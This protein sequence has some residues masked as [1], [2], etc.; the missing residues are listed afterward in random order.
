[1]LLRSI[2]DLDTAAQACIDLSCCNSYQVLKKQRQLTCHMP[3]SEMLENNRF[4]LQ[5]IVK[6]L[7]HAAKGV[8]LATITWL[9]PAVLFGIRNMVS[10]CL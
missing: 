6:V 2:F 9:P 5:T 1:M 8:R 4:V 7:D 3:C 10:R